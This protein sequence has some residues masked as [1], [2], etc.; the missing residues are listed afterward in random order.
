MLEENIN[1][2]NYDDL[3]DKEYGNEFEEIKV[4]NPYKE[5]SSGNQHHQ[6][7][8]KN[9]TNSNYLDNDYNDNS[10]ESLFE[11]IRTINE[12]DL[13]SKIH[14][15]NFVEYIIQGIKKTVKCEDS[16]I[17]QILYTGLSSYIGD[18]PINLGILAPTSEGKTYPVEETI[19]FFPKE[20]VYKI[21]SMSAKALIREKGILVDQNN[22]PIEPQLNELKTK[23]AVTEDKKEQEKLNKEIR[24]LYE[25]SKT[26]IDLRNKI[27]VFLE[28][29]NYELW[30]I[31]KPILS[32]D[33]FEIEFPFVD[34]TERKGHHTRKIVVHGWPSC[35]F[36]SAKDE[37]RWELWP[38]IKSRFL[39][40]SPNMI[41]QKYQESIKLISLR[42][43][44][45][46]SIQQEIIISDQEIENIKQCILLIKQNI[47][48]LN[49][50]NENKKISVWI[51]YHKLLENEL[52]ASK[53]SDV[54]FTKRI[55]SL[56]NVI[57]IVK[58]NLRK[59][60]ILGDET[61][62][63]AD[64]HDLKEVL[65]ITQNFDGIPK[66]KLDFFI[67]IF[68]PLFKSKSEPD[69]NCDST[70][71]EDRIAIT[72][73]D[74]CEFYKE[75]IG[76][77]ISTDNMKKTYLNELINNGIIDYEFSNIHTKKYIYFPLV[78]SLFNQ[79]IDNKEYS[80]S[81]PSNFSGFDQ[82]SQ[83]NLPIYEKIVKNVSK[84]WL[85]SEIIQL[86]S[87]RIEFSDIKGP[88]SDYLNTHNEFQLLYYS[89]NISINKR[90]TISEFIRQYTDSKSS[91]FQFDQQR[92]LNRCFLEKTESFL[93]NF[94]IFDQKDK[95]YEKETNPHKCNFCNKAFSTIEKH[96]KHSINNHEGIPA[97]PDKQMIKLLKENGIQVEEKG[98]EWEV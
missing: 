72:S 29:P 19:K 76:K 61:S 85:F 11:S 44:L 14:T 48:N 88:L 12:L 79:S 57:P 31:L 70:K 95:V 18:D 92:S 34:K 21:G 89:D 24:Q 81:F 9:K 69:S 20:D 32:H 27:L 83:L 17:T 42:K 65:F 2:P 91:I 47:Q 71:T 60:L 38:E 15:N 36:C 51:P 63:I 39:I 58:L 90:L 5:N 35:I 10:S 94:S 64:L 16:L 6:Q 62:V 73:K 86:I 23:R 59:I 78:D 45:P 46:N 8:K 93:S 1:E 4:K 97:Q 84:T 33:S 98:N 74:L 80:S 50:K 30:N 54:R 26:L 75:K 52:P 87:G 25:N 77:S 41:P 13:K 68:C 55:F 82:T 3:V 28:P 66:F 67:N 7:N 53:G 49:T 43:G 96:L 22:Y 56:L 40:T 37:S